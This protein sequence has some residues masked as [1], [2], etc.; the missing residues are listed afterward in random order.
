MPP[1]ESFKVP[2]V[3]RDQ[4]GESTTWEAVWRVPGHRASAR[5]IHALIASSNLIPALIRPVPK[6]NRIVKIL[7]P[8][9]ITLLVPFHFTRKRVRTDSALTA[10]D[11]DEDPAPP[12]ETLRVGYLE[13][14]NLDSSRARAPTA[15]GQSPPQAHWTTKTGEA[16]EE[17]GARRPKSRD[18]RWRNRLDADV[19]SSSPGRKVAPRSNL[20]A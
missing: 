18:S 7:L 9:L 14:Q 16:P 6:A 15:H 5:S 19:S 12:Q 20:L 11:T 17:A 2:R 13:S 3:D 4:R 8:T 1:P 10:F